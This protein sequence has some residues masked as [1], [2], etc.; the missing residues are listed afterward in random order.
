MNTAT[1]KQSGKPEKNSGFGADI[2]L[3]AIRMSAPE[4]RR[5]CASLRQGEFI[6]RLVL[7]AA[8]ALHA[9]APCI[10]YADTAA[11]GAKV[12]F[13]KPVRQ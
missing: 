6:A 10:E 3:D 1:Y 12:A 7:R 4:R 5:A 8:A 13:A 11:G 9:I 2:C